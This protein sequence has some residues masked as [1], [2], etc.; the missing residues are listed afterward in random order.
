MT[1]GDPLRG[2]R[3]ASRSGGHYPLSLSH[4]D[5][6]T[7]SFEE[8]SH[9][10]VYLAS[11]PAGPSALA[12]VVDRLLDHLEEEARDCVQLVVVSGMTMA[13]AARELEWWLP[14]GD[15]DRKRVAR[16]IR[17]G[18]SQL[19]SWLGVPWIDVLI[20]DLLPAE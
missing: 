9:H 20:G 15:E 16:R 7:L 6:A 19:R 18:L 12:M 13:E 1:S 8:L 2:D 5:P 4:L 10:D 11:E 3:A 14:S 17:Q